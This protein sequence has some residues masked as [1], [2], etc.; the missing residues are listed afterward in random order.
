MTSL[1]EINDLQF[2]HAVVQY[3]RMIRTFN[4]D[5]LEL[6]ELTNMSTHSGTEI[7]LLLRFCACCRLSLFKCLNIF[8]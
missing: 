8:R 5:R 1:S 4:S 2:I 7:L 6:V 3:R